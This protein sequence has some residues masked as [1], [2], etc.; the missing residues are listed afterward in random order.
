MKKIFLTTIFVIF[1]FSLCIAQNENKSALY[2]RANEMYTKGRFEEAIQLYEKI[3]ADGFTNYKVEYNLAN[4]YLKTNPPILAKAI[5]HYERALKLAPRD[6]EI[7]YNLEYARSLI[8]GKLP[9]P[10]KSWLQKQWGDFIS[11]VAPPETVMVL[12][13]LYFLAF[14]CLIFYLIFDAHK[15][16]KTFKV[17]AIV[18]AVLFA[19]VIPITYS[20]LKNASQERGVV[21]EDELPARSGPGEENK[22]LFKVYEG[23]SVK[24]VDIRNGWVEVKLP[25]GLTGWLPAEKV[26]KI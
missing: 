13:A 3:L 19:L 17:I 25:N 5:L 12:S 21:L 7:R 1:A 24:K 4:A 11:C 20:S 2:N 14:L 26:E 22:E 15:I 8:R 9:E 18:S 16:K 6:P 10:N 23:M